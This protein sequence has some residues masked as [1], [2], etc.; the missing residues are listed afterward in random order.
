MG[1]DRAASAGLASRLFGR[2]PAHT[3]ALLRAAW[4]LAV[5]P[6]LARRTEVLSLDHRVLRLRVPDARWTKV[7]HRMRRDILARLRAVAGELAPT[8]LG[9]IEGGIAPALAVAPPSPAPAVART[10]PDAVASGAAAIDDIEIRER[11]L[12]TARRYLGR[13]PSSSTPSD[14][15]STPSP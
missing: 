10:L 11:F 13:S 12:A 14:P 6:E 2:D 9:F 15:S 4:P 5:G 1:M 3:L 7:L 8:G